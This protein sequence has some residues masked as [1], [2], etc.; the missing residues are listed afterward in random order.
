MPD[1]NACIYWDANLFLSYIN[2]HPDR[3]LTLEALLGNSADGT[4][5][6]YTSALTTVEVAFAACEQQ[7]RALDPVQEQKIDALWNDQDVVSIV[8]YHD[9]IGRKRAI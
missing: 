7:R 4:V 6:V 5:Q 2:E 1:N 9:A 3:I 8:E